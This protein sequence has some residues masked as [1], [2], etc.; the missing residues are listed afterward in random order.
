MVFPSVVDVVGRV[1]VSVAPVVP[2]EVLEEVGDVSDPAVV[3]KRH[4]F[5]ELE[6]FTFSDVT[7]KALA[8][9]SVEEIVVES[10]SVAFVA[11]VGNAAEEETV[12][13]WWLAYR[14]RKKTLEKKRIQWASEWS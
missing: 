1:V 9:V 6:T 11:G 4:L 10:V 7:F 5:Y 12:E 14:S 8:A 13:G 3:W 2:W